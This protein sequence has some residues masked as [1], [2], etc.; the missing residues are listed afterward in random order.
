VEDW[1]RERGIEVLA[2]TSLREPQVVDRIAEIGPDCC[3]VVAYGGLITQDLLRIPPLG[4]INLHYSLLPAYRG[5][6][7]VQRAVLDGCERTGVTVFRLVPALDAGPV[8]CQEPVD[9]DPEATSGDLLDH[10]TSIGA[11]AMLDALAMAQAGH[12]PRP[13]TH[14]DVSLAPK[15][16]VDEARLDVTASSRQIV[17]VVRAMSPEPGAWAYVGAQRF[18]VLRA[19]V[20]EEPPMA[21]DP[22]IGELVATKR[23][24]CV[25]TGDGWIELV[26]VQAMGKKPMSGADW[27]RGAWQKGMCLE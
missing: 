6:A 14:E 19:R 18:K 16:T 22:V 26:Q 10:L 21:T 17:N 25:R 12:A 24:V 7:P 1:A 20:C 11:S 4:W 5:A 3:P 8:F 15:V 13:Q 9:I 27:A 2:P 23:Q